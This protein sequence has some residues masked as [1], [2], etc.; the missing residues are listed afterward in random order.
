MSGSI[1]DTPV[2]FASFNYR[3]GPL[4]F[5]A[6]VEANQKG[7]LN[8]GLRDQLVAL[9][10]LKQNI[11][12]FGGDPAKVTVFGQSAGAVSVALLSLNSVLDSYARG[13]IL[14]SGGATSTFLFDAARRQSS[15]DLFIDS[16]PGCS[17]ASQDTFDCV[18]NASSDSLLGAINA[19]LAKED[20]QYPWAPTLDGPDGLLPELPSSLYAKGQFARIP[21][22]SGNTVDEAT[23]FTAPT[24]SSTDDV[25]N[26]VVNNYTTTTDGTATPELDAA[27]DRLLE[28]Y[29]DDPV[30]GSPFNTGNETF[31]LSSQFKRGAAILGDL[32]FHSLRRHWTQ[33]AVTAGVK[34]YGYL[35]SGPPPPAA[36]VF[37]PSFGVAHGLE[38]LYVFGTNP[39]GSEPFPNGSTTDIAL[40]QA[41]MDYWISFAS[42]LDPNDGKGSQRPSWPEY[43][44]DNPVLLELNSGNIATIP[45]GQAF[46][47]AYVIETYYAC[48]QDNYRAEQIGFINANLEVFR[49]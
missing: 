43:T 38:T 13:A 31:G 28:I 35:F 21:F 49:R 27:V 44:L 23:P 12:S 6:G 9:E 2:V 5:P 41:M 30:S 3:L 8:L 39:F 14:E 16:I 4:G 36:G 17:S 42:S 29:P 18:R 15:W 46:L 19:S 48:L 45:V 20:E 33:T 25:R 34:G 1:Q 11:G 40:S 7:A 24:T 47:A 26:I 10:W 22:I 37:P 32:M